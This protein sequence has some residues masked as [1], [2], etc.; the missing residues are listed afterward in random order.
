[1]LKFIPGFRSNKKWKMIIACL[2]YIMSLFIVF[3]MKDPFMLL[4]YVGSPVA[5]LNFVSFVRKT[6]L[7]YL[8]VAGLGAFLLVVGAI[9]TSIIG[10]NTAA[11]N[12]ESV[13]TESI[14]I[15]DAS[16]KEEAA[17]TKPV[18]PL[19]EALGVSEEQFTNINAILSKCDIN[20]VKK[21]Q[22]NEAIDDKELG[23]VGY[24]ISADKGSM[25][26]YLRD[27][28]T[29][30]VKYNNEFLYQNGEVA[31]TVSDILSRPDLEILEH[32]AKSEQFA[33]YITG[34]IRNNSSKT[35]SYAQ[36][37][38]NLYNGESLVGSTLDNINNL[39]PN[40][41]WEFK[42]LVLGDNTTSY[43]IIEVTG[44]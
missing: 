18:D 32:T 6:T 42:A 39:G 34:K 24:D 41:V 27:G 12:Q 7:S 26:L 5:L 29:K 33:S 25:E 11:G 30:W 13:T 19:Q 3:E 44:F 10:G 21:I 4:A 23:L 15:K 35:Y 16:A 40:E 2:Y 17:S 22:R 9:G 14:D 31:Q 20:N 1:M 38:I 36:V 28:E 43:K 8:A 37:S